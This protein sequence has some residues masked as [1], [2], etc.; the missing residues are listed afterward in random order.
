MRRPARSCQHKKPP[1]GAKH[2]QF[3]FI[4]GALD[5]YYLIKA[6][7]LPCLASVLP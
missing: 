5:M 4:P 3:N 6:C 2:N 1:P 7:V